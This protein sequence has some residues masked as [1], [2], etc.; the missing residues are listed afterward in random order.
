MGGMGEPPG[1]TGIGIGMIALAVLS[2]A[3][4]RI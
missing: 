1:N 3:N 2:S 4:N